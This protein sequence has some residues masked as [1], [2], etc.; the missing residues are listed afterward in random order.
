MVDETQAQFEERREKEEL[1]DK[2]LL[3]DGPPLPTDTKYTAAKFI[4]T[5]TGRKF[6]P[7]YPD[8]AAISVI[9]FAHAI[10]NQCRYSGHARDFYSVAQHSCLLATYTEKVLKRPAVECLQILTHD[11]PEGYLVDI[12]RPVK[13]YMPEYRKWDHGINEVI[14]EW[15]GVSHLPIPDYQDELDGRIIVDERAQLMSDSGNDW[16]HRLD[17]LGIVIEPW[18][19][20]R[21]ELQFLLQY[22]AYT[23]EA[24]GA[25]YYIREGWGLNMHATYSDGGATASDITDLIEVD[26]RGGVGRVKVRS[27]NGMLTRD[28]Q[29]G[30]YPRPA[31]RWLH[32]DFRIQG[33]SDGVRQAG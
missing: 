14:R 25:P 23:A 2:H 16:G 19:P 32:G 3:T 15:L 29:A 28:P 31:W 24:F 27:E 17:P 12:A 6:Y 13:Q 18:E 9:D 1:A 30:L 11:A 33:V 7:L 8:R 21:A 4:E 5:Y 20:R 10:S 22:A 26:L